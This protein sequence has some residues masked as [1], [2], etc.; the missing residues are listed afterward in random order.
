MGSAATPPDLN[1]GNLDR[2][3][4]RSLKFEFEASR[5]L[6]G[7]PLRLPPFYL[8]L[9]VSADGTVLI[10]WDDRP[11]LSFSSAVKHR[12]PESI[13]QINANFV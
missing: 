7:I 4:S 1:F 12:F 10:S 8:C 6:G 2:S 9:A 13:K 5:P 11:L 3:S